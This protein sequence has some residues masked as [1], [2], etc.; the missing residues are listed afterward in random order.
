MYAWVYAFQL[1]RHDCVHAHWVVCA[2]G[3]ASVHAYQFVCSCVR[4]RLPARPSMHVGV[5]ACHFE[6][7]CVH[8]CIICVFVHVRLSVRWRACM[9]V[10]R[11][12][13]HASHFRSKFRPKL[14]KFISRGDG[15]AHSVESKCVGEGAKTRWGARMWMPMSAGAKPLQCAIMCDVF[16][17]NV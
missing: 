16:K 5:R 14:I 17:G 6:R 13:G 11:S 10:V 3:R 12:C 8:A 7:S 4:A 1:C 9:S 15:G 2:R